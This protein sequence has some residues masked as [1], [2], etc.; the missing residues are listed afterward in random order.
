MVLLRLPVGV[1]V[2]DDRPL[3]ELSVDES[4]I[5]FTYHD[6][7]HDLAKIIGL[8]QSMDSAGIW[9]PKPTVDDLLGWIV[10]QPGYDFEQPWQWRAVVGWWDGVQW[11]VEL[12]DRSGRRSRFM[13]GTLAD[14]A[15]MAVRAVA[16]GAS[17]K[18]TTP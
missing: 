13:W 14:A 1:P 18:E 8:A 5:W 9:W 15:A 2:S 16:A 10:R 7:T 4:R 3:A 12:R 11:S 6:P 17:P